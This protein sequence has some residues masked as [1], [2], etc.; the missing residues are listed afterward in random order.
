MNNQGFAAD[1]K[2]DGLDFYLQIEHCRFSYS[3]GIVIEAHSS[4]VIFRNNTVSNI[5]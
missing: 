2:S 1:I 3:Q 5:S 4:S